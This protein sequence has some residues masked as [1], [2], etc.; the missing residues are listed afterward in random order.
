MF[1]GLIVKMGDD[2]VISKS[3]NCC[4]LGDE[5]GDVDDKG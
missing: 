3:Y 5:G 1:F 2:F 4:I